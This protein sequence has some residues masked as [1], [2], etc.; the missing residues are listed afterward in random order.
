MLAGFPPFYDEHPFG[1]YQKIL[2][3]RVEFP[4]HFDP[5]AKDLVR[6]LLTGDRT[7]RLGTYTGT[8]MGINVMRMRPRLALFTGLSAQ[9]S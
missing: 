1:I 9:F 7:K 5:K 2:S 4:R 3:G 8:R 6:R